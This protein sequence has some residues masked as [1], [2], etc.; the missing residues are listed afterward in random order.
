MSGHKREEHLVRIDVRSLVGRVSFQDVCQVTSGKGILLGHVRS[1]VG[2]VSFQDVC[3]VTS[4]K[5]IL[6]GHMSGH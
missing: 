6:L 3:Q 2:R 5:G 4:G 1:L